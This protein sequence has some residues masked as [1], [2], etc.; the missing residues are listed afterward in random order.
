MEVVLVSID[1]IKIAPDRDHRGEDVDLDD[2]LQ[3][4]PVIGFVHPLLVLPRTDS[5]IY[6]LLAGH[7]RL[8]A[9]RKLGWAEV[10]VVVFATDDLR[11]ELATIDENLARKN[12][13]SIQRGRQMARQKEI[14]EH[15]HP[16]TRH[17]G[18]RRGH[19]KRHDGNLNPKPKSF[20][21]HVADSSGRSKRSVSRDIKVAECGAP[22]L[23]AAVEAGIVKTADAERIAG[24]PVEQQEIEVAKIID[25][26]KQRAQRQRDDTPPPSSSTEVAV[27]PT[28]AS[29]AALAE[30]VLTAARDLQVAI[31][32][33]EITEPERILELNQQVRDILS[34]VTLFVREKNAMKTAAAPYPAAARAGK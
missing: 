5:G 31:K 22:A 32:Q 4:L 11:K 8:R 19:S 34:E 29:P 15:L 3:S 9:A 23:H 14:Y 10:P 24:L 33:C 20:V 26:K 27:A 7:R 6:E 30:A 17:G 21:D 1:C 25:E 18:S 2:L 12:L 16:E 13:N 28:V